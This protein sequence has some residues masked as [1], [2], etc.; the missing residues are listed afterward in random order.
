[1]QEASTLAT[2][3]YPETL[4]RIFILGAP[5]FF[6]TVWSWIK[7]WF[8]PITVSKIFIL[9]PAN[10][11]NVLSEYIEPA[12]IP[13]KYGG[14]LEWEWGQ[15]PN[16]EPDIS[17]SLTWKR[18][19]AGEHGA[20]AFPIG[21]IRWRA[22]EDGQTMSAYALGSVDG[23]Q[24][25]DEIA[26]LPIPKDGELN[27]L[28]SRP[29]TQRAPPSTSGEHTHP[30]EGID[31][32]PTSGE[33]PTDT[34]SGSDA[35]SM[36]SSS[37]LSN[38]ANRTIPI[39]QMD[40][41]A[42][43]DSQQSAH[44]ASERQDQV[45]QGTSDMRQDQQAGTHAEGVG[46]H[47][48]PA[49]VEHGHGDKT[50]TMEPGTIGQAPKDVVVP[51][52]KEET[53]SQDAPSYVDQAKAT[54]GSAAATASAVGAGLASKVGLGGS[55][56]SEEENKK[57]EEEKARREEREEQDPQVDKMGD[58]EVEDFIRSQYAT[59]ANPSAKVKTDQE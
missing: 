24:R 15:L 13:K 33:T 27:R 46:S 3:H 54:V 39:Q 58:V 16:L 31:Q 7:R 50:R 1:M 34:P 29:Q 4:D 52:K 43:L 42:K 49:V 47:A 30:P 2:A 21:P 32:F 10:T 19:V 28:A 25:E 5:S 12:S 6:P 26:S 53:E 48:T 11:Y 23:K 37:K 36:S 38:I 9:T 45:R 8:D 22:S 18:P 20:K 44:S 55:A 14:E 41:A 35:Q 40:F 57:E 17:D 59:H 56:H 51:E